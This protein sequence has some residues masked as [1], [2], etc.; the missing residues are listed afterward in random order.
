MFKLQFVGG[1][2]PGQGEGGGL[3]VG[4]RVA[5]Q[6]HRQLLPHLDRLHAL[7]RRKVGRQPGAA[8]CRALKTRLDAIKPEMS[9]LR[10]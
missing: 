6:T 3:Y 5:P 9:I 10:V 1:G 8:L 2:E 7:Q 4:E